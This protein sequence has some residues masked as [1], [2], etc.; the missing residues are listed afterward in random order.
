MSD[1]YT[2]F[3]TYF[4]PDP[5]SNNQDRE[6]EFEMLRQRQSAIIQM[7]DE[8][9]LEALER[10]CDTLQSQGFNP[11]EWLQCSQTN[12]GFVLNESGL[13]IPE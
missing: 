7:V 1:R 13:Y 4:A 2:P 11:D 12:M 5:D 10:V 6:A 8:T 3:H 9:D